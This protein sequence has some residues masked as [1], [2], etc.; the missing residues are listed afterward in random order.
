MDSPQFITERIS[1]DDQDKRGAVFNFA[2][3]RKNSGIPGSP[4]ASCSFWE[5]A[6]QAFESDLRWGIQ[7]QLPSIESFLI[8]CYFRISTYFLKNSTFIFDDF[9][10]GRESAF[11]VITA[12]A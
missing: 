4:A 9:I 2:C 1:G 8:K 7:K 3:Y 11:P 10:T 5:R 12:K 6:L